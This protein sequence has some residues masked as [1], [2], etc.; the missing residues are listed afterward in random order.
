M[1]GIGA[2]KGKIKLV[3][4]IK[5]ME[6]PMKA[7]SVILKTGELK[8]PS[9][10]WYNNYTNP[11]ADSTL[12]C[13]LNAMLRHFTAHRMGFAVDPDSK[14]P[15]IFHLACRA[16]L[17]ITTYYL[18]S[19]ENIRYRHNLIRPT[20]EYDYKESVGLYIPGEVLTSLG[21]TVTLMPENYTHN[22]LEVMINDLLYRAALGDIQELKDPFTQLT[23]PDIILRAVFMYV[24]DMCHSEFMHDFVNSINDNH[25]KEIADYLHSFLG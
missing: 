9:Y 10:S 2:F 7:V 19:T 6:L 5:D 18:A 3:D 11:K 20:S 14:M 24:K 25:P 21:K 8:Y 17:M 4:I 12:E 16:A 13:N 15:H 1:Y 22:R 23:T